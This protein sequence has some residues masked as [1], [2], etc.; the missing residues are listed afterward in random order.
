[1]IV[2]IA[3]CHGYCYVT[4]VVSTRLLSTSLSRSGSNALNPVESPTDN[5][6]EIALLVLHTAATLAFYYPTMT[7]H[8]VPFHTTEAPSSA[9]DRYSVLPDFSTHAARINS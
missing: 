2:P 5:S 4:L 9:I 7:R 8:A 3:Q 1:M 6:W